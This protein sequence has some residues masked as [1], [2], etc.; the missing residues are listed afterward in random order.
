MP[1]FEK[2]QVDV[3]PEKAAEVC[4]MSDAASDPKEREC[5]HDRDEPSRLDGNDAPKQDFVTWPETSIC[6]T[7]TEH[8]TG[9]TKDG[10]A[11]RKDKREQR[12]GDAADE[13]EDD[14]SLGAKPSFH[15]VPEEIECEHV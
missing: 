5:S 15:S 7:Y 3:A 14:E 6:Q 8:G 9:C 12:T 2:E 13:V 11:R 1:P 10:C 4:K